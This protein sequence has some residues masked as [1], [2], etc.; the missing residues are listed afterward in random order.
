MNRVTRKFFGYVGAVVILLSCGGLQGCSGIS[1]GA[2]DLVGAPAPYIRFTM[3]DGTQLPLVFAEGKTA[4]IIFWTTWCGH[5]RG[6][7]EE[8]EQI[9]KRYKRRKDI[10]FLAASLDKADQLRA[11]EGRI[12][13]QGLSS[14]MHAFSGN[15]IQDEAFLAFKGESVPYLVVVD[16][17]G[18]VRSVASSTSELEEYL[19]NRFGSS[20]DQR[21]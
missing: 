2:R 3:L 4:A 5:S 12:K 17:R 13:S 11:V 19:E 14:V 20:T 8:F 15:D 1:Q 16:S 18:V 21:P 6:T 9:A 10:V 7:I